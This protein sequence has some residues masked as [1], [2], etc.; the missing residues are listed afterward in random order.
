MADVT[1]H[2]HFDVTYLLA[3]PTCRSWHD[4]DVCY[5]F[6]VLWMSSSGVGSRVC[7]YNSYSFDD[8]WILCS[9]CQAWNIMKK[10]MTAWH[11]KYASLSIC[12][13]IHCLKTS[14]FVGGDPALGLGGRKIVALKFCEPNFPMTFSLETISTHKFW[15]FF[16][17]F[18]IWNVLCLKSIDKAK[19]AARILFWPR[20]NGR[21]GLRREAPRH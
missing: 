1:C 4:P 8:A 7:W 3:R 20:Q 11:A 10:E 18:S 17:P 12:F 6:G 21:E 15:W 16:T 5:V 13:E 14:G 2:I 19:P 9:R